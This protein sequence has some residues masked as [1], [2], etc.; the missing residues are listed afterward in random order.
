MSHAPESAQQLLAL[1][2]RHGTV[3]PAYGGIPGG[4]QKLA[5][6]L[7][8]IAQAWGLT[9]QWLPVDKDRA[10]LLVSIDT[11]IDAPWLV[12]DS[13]LDTVGADDMTVEPF[14]AEIRDGRL[15]GRGACDTKGTGAA[16]LWALREVAAREEHPV[17]P[18]VLFTHDEESGMT[19][20][21]SFIEHTRGELGRPA[22]VIVGEPTELHPVVAHNGIL[23]WRLITHGQACH[24]SVPHQGR[25][26]IDAMRQ[27]LDRL[28][29]NYIAGLDAEHELTG[30]AVCTVNTIAGGTAV[31][32][33][34]DRCEV[35]IDR[36]LV[37]GESADD[38]LPAVERALAP[39]W[40]QDPTVEF[41]QV[42]FASHPPLTA[43]LNQDLCT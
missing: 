13:H 9:T 32:V 25:S 5:L 20:I 41:E 37:P 34:P 6:R 39:L 29:Q 43:D 40:D 27:A 1:M 10:N 11:D 12:F 19:G 23:R 3:N 8:D 31:N 17:R 35:Q 2:V 22:G 14:G 36:R 28:E 16:M 33:I 7:A 30:P 42:V 15:Y 38:V 21:Q 18:S 24:S 4:S 26:A